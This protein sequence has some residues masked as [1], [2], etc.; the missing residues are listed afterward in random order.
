MTPGAGKMS[1][2]LG[3][4][5]FAKLQFSL[6][7]GWNREGGEQGIK[8]IPSKHKGKFSLSQVL[9]GCSAQSCGCNLKAQLENSKELLI[10]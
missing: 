8:Q 9:V 10:L 1:C 2:F 7:G 5:F 3:H 6:R 4:S